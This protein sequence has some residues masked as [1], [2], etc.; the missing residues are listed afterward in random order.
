MKRYGNYQDHWDLE[1]REEELFDDTIKTIR[2]P[3]VDTSGQ[4]PTQE[5][6]QDRNSKEV[7]GHLPNRKRCK[8]DE[9]WEKN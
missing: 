8:E 3:F 4:F 5:E 9:Y 1:D 6:I 2:M 7:G